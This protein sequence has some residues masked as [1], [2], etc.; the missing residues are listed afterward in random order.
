MDIA[1]G[2]KF[3]G[4]RGLIS[5]PGRETAVHG[6]NTS[7][8]QLYHGDHLIIIDSGFGISN[9]GES[10]MHRILEKKESLTIHVLLTHFHWDHVQGL[11]FFHPI[12][13]PT[14]NLHIYSTLDPVQA[15]CH[16]EPLFDGSY[17][18][19]EGVDSMPSNIQFHQIDSKMHIGS[20]EIST[21][22]L[23][24]MQVQVGDVGVSAFRFDYQDKSLVVATDHEARP[25]PCNEGLVRFAGDTDLL[26]HDGQY[27]EEEY[28]RRQ[29]WGHS[30]IRQA[31]DNAIQAQA[32]RMLI[33][34]HAPQRTD[35][36]LS[37]LR[38][39]YKNNETY[40]DLKF[41]FARESTVYCVK[42][43]ETSCG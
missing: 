31:L 14:T 32:K 21:Y 42:K 11:P 13:F 12:Y 3:W 27:T 5:S 37:R 7:C 39:I 15:K 4:T 43:G 29:G 18:P 16:L 34:H 36:E 41:D 22:P 24:H 17:S 38:R 25:S 40:R 28:L 26:V 2:M 9:F 33:T 35:R 30:N 10:L 19:F 20:L 8:M 23:D 6:G 1:L